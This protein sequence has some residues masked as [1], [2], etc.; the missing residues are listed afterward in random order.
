VKGKKKR[1]Y[2]PAL[3]KQAFARKAAR[4]W[5]RKKEQGHMT[6]KLG[7]AALVLV[8]SLVYAGSAQAQGPLSFTPVQPC[9]IVDTR[10]PVG[11][12]GGPKMNANQTRDFPILGACTLPGTAV[13]VVFNVTIVAPTA[14]GNL[15][16][17]PAGTA[18]P[19]ASIVN[20]ATGDGPTANGAIIPMGVSVPPGN[21]V[22]VRNDMPGSTTGQ[23]HVV[24]DTNGYFQ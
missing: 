9:R 1:S 3:E 6:K 2:L 20:F 16:M 21:H 4:G 11:A 17:F 8:G 7:W 22:S 19:V 14:N 18:A 24:I 13:A 5:S 10:G 15:R 12:T 23:V